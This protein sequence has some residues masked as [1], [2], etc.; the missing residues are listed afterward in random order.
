[1]NQT[2]RAHIAGLLRRAAEWVEPRVVRPSVGHIPPRPLPPRAAPIPHD[3]DKLEC[4]IYGS[5]DGTTESG[6]VT[7]FGRKRHRGYQPIGFPG[8]ASPPPRKM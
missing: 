5:S 3:V 7:T 2:L 4:T 8:H 1:M 6:K